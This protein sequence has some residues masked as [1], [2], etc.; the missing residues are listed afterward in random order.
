MKIED[1]RNAFIS[2]IP[3]EY[4]AHCLKRMAERDITRKDISN[5]IMHGEII[6][7][8]PLDADNT[9]ETSYPSC[10]I[11]WVDIA[12]SGAI[13]VVVGYNRHRIIII[14]AYKPDEDRWEKDFKTRKETK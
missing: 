4:K 11:L 10:L 5:C 8:Y 6:E 2:G 3:V 13:H 14:S 1:I 7:D 12:E 9:S